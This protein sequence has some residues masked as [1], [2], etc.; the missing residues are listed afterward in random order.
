MSL[1]EE[2]IV[3]EVDKLLNELQTSPEETHYNAVIHEG[4]KA[5]PLNSKVMVS[6]ESRPWETDWPLATIVFELSKTVVTNPYH[7]HFAQVAETA[8]D[9]WNGE[10]AALMA[11]KV[12]G[13][14]VTLSLPGVTRRTATPL[15]RC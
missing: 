13:F 15:R 6:M 8:K 7:T 10:T 9:F 5:S 1:S 12:S 3:T 11:S 4:F 2:Q 14:S